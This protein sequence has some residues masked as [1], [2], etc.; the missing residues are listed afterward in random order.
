VRF[1]DHEQERF[2]FELCLALGGMTH[3]EMMARMSSA[4][5][6]RWIAFF[7]IAPFGPRQEFMR[8]GAIAAAV[9]N[10]QRASTDAKVW[11]PAD[12]FPHLKNT[13]PD[14]EAEREEKD[15]IARK[16]QA[17]MAAALFFA[18]APGA[19]QHG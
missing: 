15:R 1:Q 18:Q 8:A 5:L 7:D 17:A 11:E 16:V 2:Q 13:E 4:E 14:P 12:F 10:S 19:P 6:S 9:C 3:G